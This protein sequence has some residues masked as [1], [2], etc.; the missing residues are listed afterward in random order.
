MRAPLP[1]LVDD[2]APHPPFERPA[3]PPAAAVAKRADEPVVNGV[4]SARFLSDEGNRDAQEGGKPLAVETL[5]VV[6]GRAHD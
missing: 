1:R 2:D 4:A 5:D 3:A 6:R